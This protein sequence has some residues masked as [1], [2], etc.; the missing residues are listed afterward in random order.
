MNEPNPDG[1]TKRVGREIHQ[2]V[3]QPFKPIDELETLVDD[4]GGTRKRE[5][6]MRSDGRKEGNMDIDRT[7]EVEKIRISG[8]KLE[9]PDNVA[10]ENEYAGLLAKALSEK[11][12]ISIHVAPKLEEDSDFPDIWLELAT[13][14]IGVQITHLDRTTIRDLNTAGEYAAE[15]STESIAV[16][17]IGAIEQK[18]KI[19]PALAAKTI[20]LL[21]SPYPIRPV[22]QGPIRQHV[23]G[24]GAKNAYKETWLASLR[25]PAFEL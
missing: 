2:H 11:L 20:L 1:P 21:I 8:R 22:M 24:V 4:K 9:P 14:R 13:D 6:S 3:E 7:G 12:G 18:Q 17:I 23:A 10:D 19:D 16:A 15:I 5:I 25:E